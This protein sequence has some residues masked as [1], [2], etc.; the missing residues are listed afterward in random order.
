MS[1]KEEEY[2]EIFLAEAQE[3]F[4]D[5]NRL[6]TD[7][8]KNLED[9]NIVNALFRITHTLKGNAAG[10][11]FLDISS[12]AHVIEDLFGE[13]R[14]GKLK[15]TKDM[16]T[17]LFR[18]VDTL[19]ALINSLKDGSKVSFRGIKTKL[20]VIIN[21]AKEEEASAAKPAEEEENKVEA[22]AAKKKAPA[23][24]KAKSAKK[25]T[26]SAKKEEPKK[27][28]ENEEL[29]A[30]QLEEINK[31]ISQDEEEED[32]GVSE[33][34]ATETGNK[35]TFSDLVQVPVKKLDNLLNL[36]GELIIERDRIIAAHSQNGNSNEYARLNRISS[37][38]QYSVMDVRLVQVGFLFN[39]FHRVVRDAAAVEAKNVNL[40]LKGTNTEI[41]RNILQI[42]SD[43]LIHLIRNCVSHGIESPE[44]RKKNK[45]SEA[46]TVTLAARND[47]DGV[48]I[49][50]TDDGKGIDVER[51]REKALAKGLV[52]KEMLPM[53]NEQDM[54]ML[55]FEAGFSTREEVTSLSGRGVGMDVVKKALDSIGGN[56]TL[57]TEKGKGTTI[58]LK[59]PSSMAVKGTLLFES[60]NQQYAIPLSYTE[61]VVSLYKSSIH[62]VSGGLIATHLGKTISIVFLKDLFTFYKHAGGSH[63]HLQTGF[64]DLHPEQ[65]LHVVIVTYNGRTVGLVVDKLLQQKEI[66]EKPLMKP[67]DQIKLISGVTILGNG[68]VCPVLNIAAIMS[69]IFNANLSNQKAI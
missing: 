10:M 35:I 67:L 57:H 18:A 42:I 61:A 69:T 19:G 6:L 14:E 28:V 15:L 9:K 4:E 54:L 52:T 34:E 3:N 13:V 60:E 65:Q 37:D 45:K 46:G 31:L 50:I 56:I 2:K 58:S 33:T 44:E 63:N 16:F 32:T 38:L 39:K 25:K 24:S 48:I 21:R 66:V 5:V 40:E 27:E 20:E 23:K 1:S 47:S 43:S 11:G 7:L 30:P 41:D 17:S 51:V 59:L 12:L 36:V 53:I 55:I 49:D 29:T 62:K 22:P 8:E 64:N 68:H 26:T